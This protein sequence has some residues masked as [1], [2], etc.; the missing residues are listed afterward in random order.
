MSKHGPRPPRADA[1]RARPARLPRPPGVGARLRRRRLLRG[2]DLATER[3]ALNSSL[4][5]CPSPRSTLE[6]RL[7]ARDGT[8]KALFRTHDGHPV[9]SVLMRYRDGR[10]SVCISTQSGCPLQC[11]FCAS[12]QMGFRRNLSAWEI[13]EQALFFTRVVNSTEGS[14]QVPG[15]RCRF[16]AGG[17]SARRTGPERTGPAATSGGSGGR[18]RRPGGVAGQ[19]PEQ[20]RSHGHGRTADEPRGRS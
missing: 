3:P 16:R 9:E 13:V 12:G 4:F 19:G 10:R 15:R 11:A 1:G 8:V 18:L 2:D 7:E 20:C 5:A 6:R 17:N 14:H